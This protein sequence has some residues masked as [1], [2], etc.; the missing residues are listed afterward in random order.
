MNTNPDNLKLRT[1]QCK[2]CPFRHGNQDILSPNRWTA[3]YKYLIEG[4]Q[5]ICHSTNGHI[6]RGARNWQLKLW[7]SQGIIKEPTDTALFEAM[8][9][10]G[11]EPAVID[12]DDL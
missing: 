4:T 5:H 6:C 8:R 10:H 3:I 7:H 9:S 12:K 11:V 1:N 2:T